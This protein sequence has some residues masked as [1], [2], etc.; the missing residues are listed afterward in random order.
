MQINNCPHCNDD[1]IEITYNPILKVHTLTCYNCNKYTKINPKQVDIECPE[2]ES[3]DIRYDELD[4][5]CGECGLVLSSVP[6]SYVADT[7][8]IFDWGFKL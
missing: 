3:K 5:S 2:C 4:I 8:I 1:D 7:K 6:P